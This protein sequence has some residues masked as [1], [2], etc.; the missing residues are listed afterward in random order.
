VQQ[1]LAPQQAAQ[2]R[3]GQAG[4]QR[5]TQINREQWHATP[6]ADRL[7]H[8]L[9]ARPIRAG[10]QYDAAVVHARQVCELCQQVVR[11]GEAIEAAIGRQP[12]G[13]RQQAL[14]HGV[15]PE[16]EVH[17]PLLHL[18]HA[19]RQRWIAVLGIIEQPD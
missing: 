1:C 13:E 5:R 18:D 9:L 16:Q 17:Q 15:T 2:H 8:G 19:C 12:V 14:V 10:E 6:G 4:R 11:Q 3:R 7:G